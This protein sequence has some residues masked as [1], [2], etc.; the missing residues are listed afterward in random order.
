MECRYYFCNVS[1]RVNHVGSPSFPTSLHWHTRSIYRV[2][3]VGN[4]A[5]TP[6]TLGTHPGQRKFG[7]PLK[8]SISLHIYRDS[9]SQL[10][11]PAPVLAMAS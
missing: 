1:V 6:N 3:E 8:S 9:L 7:S 5:D 2:S 11:R 4:S 10:P